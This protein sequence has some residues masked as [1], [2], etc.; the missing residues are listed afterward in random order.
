MEGRFTEIELIRVRVEA[1]DYLLIVGIDDRS[2]I[3]RQQLFDGLGVSANHPCQ[4]QLA[5]N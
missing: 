1:D 5:L 2:S 3:L 4:H